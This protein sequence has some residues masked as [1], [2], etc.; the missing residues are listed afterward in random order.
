MHLPAILAM[1]DIPLI[2]KYGELLRWK[3]C[4][5][6]G[7]PSFCSL[8]VDAATSVS[9]SKAGILAV[10][11]ASPWATVSWF[12]FQ[13]LHFRILYVF[14]ARSGICRNEIS[15]L[16]VGAIASWKLLKALSPPLVLCT[17]AWSLITALQRSR[18]HC[19][20]FLHQA[21]VA[22]P[23]VVYFAL[24]YYAPNAHSARE[25]HLQ[26]HYPKLLPRGPARHFLFAAL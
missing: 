4:N 23:P 11:F 1:H 14:P 15:P 24:L 12:R 22:L 17:A 8:H 5:L 25:A 21:L 7:L 6:Y 18:V 16:H 26:V 9:F 19:R 2:Y 20:V 10:R 3:S 13:L